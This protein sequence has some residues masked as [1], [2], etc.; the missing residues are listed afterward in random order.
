MFKKR[1][2]EPSQAEVVRIREKQAR[3]AETGWEAF[4]NTSGGEAFLKGWGKASNSDE[5]PVDR[6]KR[7]R[8]EDDDDND[9]FND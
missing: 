3:Q 2:Q 7:H 1:K 5:D 4:R 8:Q 6:L 9:F